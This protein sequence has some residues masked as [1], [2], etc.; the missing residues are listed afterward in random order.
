MLHV[1]KTALIK[2]YQLA[3]GQYKNNVTVVFS[4]IFVHCGATRPTIAC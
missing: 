3:S 1:A 4:E 2:M